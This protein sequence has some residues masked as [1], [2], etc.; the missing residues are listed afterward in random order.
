[1]RLKMKKKWRVL[2]QEKMV[3]VIKNN[4][5]LIIYIYF[6]TPIGIGTKS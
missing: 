2:A 3:H 1:M 5:R 4:V 6:L